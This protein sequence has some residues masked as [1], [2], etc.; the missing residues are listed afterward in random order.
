MDWMPK[1]VL[2]LP[3]ILVFTHGK[4]KTVKQKHQN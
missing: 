2:Y 1:R 4:Q 3:D